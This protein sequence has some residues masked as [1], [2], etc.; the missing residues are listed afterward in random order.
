MGFVERIVPS[1]GIVFVLS[2]FEKL[3]VA[4]NLIILVKGDDGFGGEFIA[5][6][7]NHGNPISVVDALS[8]S[9]NLSSRHIAGFG[10]S[11]EIPPN[12]I[13]SFFGEGVIGNFELVLLL[14]IVF[15]C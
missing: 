9:P 2:G 7:I 4:Q 14:E 10:D 6:V 8:L 12:E 15:Q 5:S 11:G 3:P 1:F 13:E